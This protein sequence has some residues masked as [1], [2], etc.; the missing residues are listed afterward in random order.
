ML[1]QDIIIEIVNCRRQAIMDHQLNFDNMKWI[2]NDLIYFNIHPKWATLTCIILS[3]DQFM[4]TM[5]ER[6]DNYPLKKQTRDCHSSIAESEKSRTCKHLTLLKTE[7]L[8]S[9]GW[10]GFKNQKT[11]G[12]WVC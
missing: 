2:P 6:L 11:R 10:T 1:L 5:K 4:I 9:G 7:A 12:K 8:L 3:D